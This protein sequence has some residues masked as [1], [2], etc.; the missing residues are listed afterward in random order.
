MFDLLIVIAAIVLMVILHEFGHFVMAKRSGMKVT[1][2][3]FGF[4]PRLWSFKRGETTYGIKAIPAGGYV[5]IIG[6]SNVEE[7]DEKDEARSY[8]Q[9]S[10]PKRLSVA[11]A[12]SVVHFLLALI[13]LWVLA[14][15]VG[16]PNP[17]HVELAG[18]LRVSSRTSNPAKAGGLKVGDVFYSIDGHKITGSD[19]LAYLIGSH[20]G[21]RLSIQVITNDGRLEN[22]SVTPIAAQDI[23]VNG[24]PLAQGSSGG[25]GA[26]GIVL[27]LEQQRK[28]PFVAVPGAFE[29]LGSITA[30]TVGGI[31][32]VFSP[33]SI[34]TLWSELSSSHA[35]TKAAASDTP[36]LMSIYGAVNLATQAAKSGMANLLFVLILINVFV[37]LINMFPML[38]LDGGHVVIAVYERIRSRAGKSYHADVN[39]LLPLAYTLLSILIILGLSV[40]YLDIRY[41]LANPFH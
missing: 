33:H 22:R 38:P 37:G 19:Q 29:Q 3:F 10:F 6:M 39:K 23:I 14:V 41:P 1:E 35:A 13:M 4:G 9:Q 27:T 28:N 36:R 15:F 17:A 8:R 5:K 11:V 16:L 20:R 34:E 26:L 18:F 2:F 31:G 30:S 32:T 21:K 25:K 24:R 40:L 7:V 12:G